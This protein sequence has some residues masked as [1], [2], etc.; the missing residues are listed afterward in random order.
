MKADIL[1][2]LMWY[3]KKDEYLSIVVVIFHQNFYDKNF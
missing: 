3:E 2:Y 1:L